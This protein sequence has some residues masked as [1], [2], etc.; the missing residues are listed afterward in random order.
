VVRASAQILEG[1]RFDLRHFGVV[2]SLSKKIYSH[3]SSLS[4]WDL[5]ATGKVTHP[6]VI[7]IG[8]WCEANAQ[9]LLMVLGCCGILGS[10]ASLKT[11]TIL[12]QVTGHAP[13]GFACTRLSDA[14]WVV[15]AMFHMTAGGFLLCFV[16]V[17]VCACASVCV[18]WRERRGWW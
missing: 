5:V 3:C 12:L 7:S 17:C 1:P 18:G 13:G 15:I 11:W 8:T 16:C 6:A 9:L 4:S 14:Q 10:V 2:V